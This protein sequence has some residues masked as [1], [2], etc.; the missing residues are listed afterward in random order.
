MSLGDPTDGGLQLICPIELASRVTS[1]VHA[2]MRAAMYAA[3]H[4]A[5]PAPIT[6]TSNSPSE[7]IRLFPDAKGRE[8]LTEYVFSQSLTGDLSESCEP[9]TQSQQDNLF[10]FA[11]PQ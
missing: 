8:D 9:A 5:W 1:A 6:I 3:S 11:L 4:P 10:K 7:Y 2:P